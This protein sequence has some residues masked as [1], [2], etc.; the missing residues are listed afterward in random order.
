MGKLIP[1]V[2]WIYNINRW[3][4]EYGIVQLAGKWAVAKANGRYMGDEE[5]F[6]IITEWF[7]DRNLAVGFVKLLL[8]N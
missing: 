8:E 7:P 2:D 3:D 4:R 6:D 5:S 1:E